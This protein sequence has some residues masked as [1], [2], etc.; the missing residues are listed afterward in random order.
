MAGFSK[1]K[2]GDG[3]TVTDEGAGVI[4]VAG[5]GGAPGPQ[6]PAGAPGPAGSTG[7]A[8]PAGPGVPAGGTAGQ[9]LTKNTATDYDTIWAAGGGGTGGVDWE[10]TGSGATGVYIPTSLV[11]AKGDLIAAAADNTVA[12]LPAGS[13]GQ[14]L[15]ADSAQTLGVKWAAAAGGG[16]V[17]GFS[18]AQ[19]SK[20]AT[21]STN[22]GSMT[23]LLL[24]TTDYTNGGGE[25]SLNPSTGVVTVTHAG[26]LIA[27][28]RVTAGST[29][30]SGTVFLATIWNGAATAELARS[31]MPGN[32]ATSPLPVPLIKS[33]AA[34]ETFVMR[35]YQNIGTVAITPVFDLVLLYV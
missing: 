32:F 15:T 26:I 8:G 21:Q 6:G 17:G 12:R 3:L 18:A 27:T 28:G 2:W 20:A 33:V 14:V 29:G 16:A 11:D 7:P 31:Y 23:T 10:D 25:F 13:N 5:V 35:S 19:F 24:D 1:V 30:S 22:T 34:G 9:V 4:T